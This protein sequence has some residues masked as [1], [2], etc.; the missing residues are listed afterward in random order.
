MTAFRY[1]VS[2]PMKVL[3]VED[4][5]LL[6]AGIRD[7]LERARYTV[8]WVRDGAQALAALRGGGRVGH[9]RCVGRSVP[10]ARALSLARVLRQRRL[11]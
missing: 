9:H 1:G 2:R 11:R 5:E 3:L 8:E 6:G 4:D 10:L 7:A